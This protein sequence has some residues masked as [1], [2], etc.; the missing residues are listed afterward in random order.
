M[1]VV[2]NAGGPGILAADALEANGLVLP[3]PS[4]AVRDRLA[5]ALPAEASTGNPVDLIASGGP[6]EFEHATSTLLGSAEVDAVL[7]IYVPVSPGGAEEVA[8]ALRRCQDAHEGGVTLLTVFMQSAGA[9]SLLAGSESRSTI[10]A[11]LFPEQAALAL[12]RAVRYGEWLRRD[13]GVVPK[14]ERIDALEARHIASSAL[15]GMDEVGGWLEPE[16]VT[17]L[18]RCFGLSVPATTVARSREDAVAA[19][20]AMGGPVVLKVVSDS[21]LHKSD[22]GGVALDVIG[23]EAVRRAYDAVTAAVPDAEGVLVQEF[24]ADGH[25]VLIGSTESADFGSLVVFGLGGVTTEL[26]GDVTFRIHPLTDVDAREMV[27]SIRG[28][29]ILEGYR[30][31]PV[32]DVTAV[33]DALLRVSEMLTLLPEIREMDLNPVKVLPPG[34]GAVVVDA[35]IR[36]AAIDPGDRP[37]LADL[38]SVSRQR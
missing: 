34:G 30:N 21:A 8:A 31:L 33:E 32:G 36:M 17:A 38:P 18:L 14:I 19:A 37:E 28:F 15:D 16:D 26:L 11:Y 22:V 29:P 12:A 20:G 4:P 25:E 2:T 24:V 27:R 23:E 6:V 13:P 5:A 7:V 9:A 35:R 1:G 3:A 10:P